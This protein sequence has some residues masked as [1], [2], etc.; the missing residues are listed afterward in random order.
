M[1]TK[2]LSKSV[3]AASLVAL[4]ATVV[5]CSNLRGGN[6]KKAVAQIGATKPTELPGQGN[7]SFVQKA[8]EVE[9]ELELTFPSKAN[10]TVA[11]H[12]HEHGDCGNAGNDAHGHWNPTK[13]NH[14]KWGQGQFHLGDIGNV[15]LDANGKG[16]LEMDTNLWTVGTGATNDVV[17]KAIMVH[18]KADDYITQ[19]TGN[20]GGRIGCGVIQLSR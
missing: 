2:K 14:G 18:E 9:M 6:S 5:S 12:I 20:A 13:A 3:F 10:Q 8:N 15:T 17:G 4:L 16:K 19:P 11:V 7:I 1:T